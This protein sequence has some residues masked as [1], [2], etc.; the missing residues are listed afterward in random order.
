MAPPC[1]SDWTHCMPAFELSSQA[2]RVLPRP[3]LDCRVFHVPSPKY[4]ANPV[5]ALTCL[6]RFWDVFLETQEE[7]LPPT[8]SFDSDSLLQCRIL[9]CAWGGICDGK[10]GI[11]S[12]WKRVRL[13]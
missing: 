7:M 2:P 1:L 13:C 6:A 12:G 3:S 9:G 8:S 5:H 10:L 4:L 11:G